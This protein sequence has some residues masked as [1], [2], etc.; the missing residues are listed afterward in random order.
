MGRKTEADRIFQVEQK[1]AQAIRDDKNRRENR[2]R[3][4]SFLLTEKVECKIGI[5]DADE[6]GRSVWGASVKF[7][8]DDGTCV[9]NLYGKTKNGAD[10]IVRMFLDKLDIKYRISK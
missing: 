3:K 8:T 6:S 2:N 4:T 1:K 5:V 10:R 9:M 7:E